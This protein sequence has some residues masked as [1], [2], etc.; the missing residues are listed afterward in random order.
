[1]V[2]S[3]CMNLRKTIGTKWSVEKHNQI[4]EQGNLL[5]G[6]DNKIVKPLRMGI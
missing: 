4:M 2:F 6:S 1:M 3:F 5:K